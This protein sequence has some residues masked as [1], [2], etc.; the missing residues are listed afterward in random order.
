MLNPKSG[1]TLCHQAQRPGLIKRSLPYRNDRVISV[2]H[3]CFFSGG[4]TSFATRFNR[5]FTTNDGISPVHREVSLPMVS[6]VATAVSRKSHLFLVSMLIFFFFFF[7]YMSLFS[8]GGQVRNSTSSSLQV[9]SWMC[10][11]EM[12]IP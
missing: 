6:L 4:S 10:T 7:S 11:R 5:L 1:L 8:N 9:P 2:L 12:R 3:E